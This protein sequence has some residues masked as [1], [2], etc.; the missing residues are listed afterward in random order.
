M[1]H[2]HKFAVPTLTV[3]LPAGTRG[4][5]LQEG[6][7]D[8]PACHSGGGAGRSGCVVPAPSGQREQS[9]HWASGGDLLG[10]SHLS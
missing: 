8:P 10:A 9:V 5:E 6:P 7:A 2:T 3:M 1:L 4:P